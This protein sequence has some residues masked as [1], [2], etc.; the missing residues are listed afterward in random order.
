MISTKSGAS[1]SKRA[2]QHRGVAI[3]TVAA[4]SA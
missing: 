1:A 2:T 4:S 3:V